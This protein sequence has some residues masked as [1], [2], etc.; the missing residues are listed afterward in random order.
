M[1]DLETLVSVCAG[2]GDRKITCETLMDGEDDGEKLPEEEEK[3]DLPPDFPPESFWLSKDAEYDWFDRNAFYERKD[4]TKGN[5]NSPKVGNPASNSSSQRF[6]ANLKSKAAMIGLPKTQKTS[7]VD[8]TN[9]RNCKPANIRLFPKRP[10]SVGKTAVAL[11]E[12]SSP[13]VSCMGRVRSKRGRKKPSDPEAA[14]SKPQEKAR[15]VERRR[16]GIYGRFISIFRSRRKERPGVE[17][18]AKPLPF[19]ESSPRRSVT[20]KPREF[21]EAAAE[22][23]GLG[24]MM[25]FASGRRSSSV[26]DDL[27]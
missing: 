15:S 9:R 8:T 5:S 20:D 18:Y 25:R 27:T 21:H 24:G 10:E 17:T 19:K 26:A 7:Y 23:P 1:V 2:T 12:P 16:I 11:A 3:P 13:K 14:A 4:S 22:P 6:S